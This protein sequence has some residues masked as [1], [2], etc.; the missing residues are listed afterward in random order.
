MSR[1][2]IPLQD[3]EDL[4]TYLLSLNPQKRKFQTVDRALLL[5]YEPFMGPL[6]RK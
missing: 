5:G 4:S 1:Y 3:L 6:G 2:D